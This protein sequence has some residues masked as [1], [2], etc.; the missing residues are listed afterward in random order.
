M[1]SVSFIAMSY[2]YTYDYLEKG[3]VDNFIAYFTS[4]IELDFH[5]F[6]ALR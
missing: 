3:V 5:D 6:V 2:M 1:A 4:Q